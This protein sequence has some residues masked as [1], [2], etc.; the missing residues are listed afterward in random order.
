MENIMICIKVLF[1]FVG[2]V[3]L[4]TAL[5]LTLFAT[6]N[7]LLVSLTGD[8]KA[9]KRFWKNVKNFVFNI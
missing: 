6:F 9:A 1:K 5:A 8:K 7:N 4:Y 3:A 2:G